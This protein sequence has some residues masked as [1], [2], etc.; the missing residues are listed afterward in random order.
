MVEFV[1]PPINLLAV[2]FTIIMCIVVMNARREYIIIPLLMTACFITQAQRIM[3]LDVG[4]P[5]LRI[6]IIFGF[7][8][9][10]LRS[11]WS[12][13]TFNAIDKLMI[14][15]MVIQTI[16]HTILLSTV[17]AF[18]FM[19]GVTI[20]ILGTYFF[21][22][23][24]IQDFTDYDRI[25]KTIVLLSIPIA[26]FMLYERASGGYNI[27]SIFGGVPEISPIRE[28][29]LRA[30]GAFSHS[31]LAGTFGASLLPLSWG[32]R[33]RNY[34]I[35]PIAGIATSLVIIIA[36][37]SSGP[38]M[39][40]L[41]GLLGIF[42]W[43]FRKNTKAIRNIFLLSL[44]LM[45]IFMK[46]PIWHLIS[47]VDVVGG[48]TGY[49]R[50]RLIDAAIHNFSGWFVF[51]IKNT[52]VWGRGLWDIT[53]QYILEG[54]SGGIIPMILFIVIMGYCFKT[55][56]SSRAKL[57][58]RLDLQKYVWSLG[59]LLFA[60]TFTFLSVS[61]FGQMVFFYYLFIA[62]ISSLNNLQEIIPGK[63][64]PSVV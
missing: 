36:S 2:T 55:I 6:L 16:T 21:V 34:R 9:F 41:F 47:R 33:Q 60:Y 63:T 23:V 39:T 61:F 45:H 8:R 1:V 12:T 29:K 54:A 31:I 15:Y 46:A 22:R 24:V 62:M 5:M 50:Y 38:V 56:G 42:L 7:I 40:F 28:G 4:F 44:I 52:E 18:V 37:S 49:H 43:F 10:Y 51:G 11:E 13:L 20:D 30:Q 27:F 17:G 64:T 35:I 19:L 32:L 26:L 59:A 58:D 25:I 57:G 14:Y 48:S 53:N 3:I